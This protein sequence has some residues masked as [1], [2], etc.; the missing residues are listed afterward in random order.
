MMLNQ[1][2]KGESGIEETGAEDRQNGRETWGQDALDR[3]RKR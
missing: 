1:Q 2:R 3:E